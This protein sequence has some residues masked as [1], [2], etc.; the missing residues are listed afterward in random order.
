M[1]I[2]TTCD[3]KAESPESLF[4]QMIRVLADGSLV[5]A[6]QGSGTVDNELE[7]IATGN[8]GSGQNGNWRLYID[9]SLDL[10]MQ[11]RLGGVWVTTETNGF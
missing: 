8:T 10:L 2:H 9:G 6:V 4:K 11:K 5:L 7:I 1:A 3:N